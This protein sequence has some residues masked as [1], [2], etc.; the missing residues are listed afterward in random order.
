MRTYWTTARQRSSLHSTIREEGLN[1]VVRNILAGA[2]ALALGAAAVQAAPNDPGR[3]KV[4]AAAKA[5]HN[6]AIER[7]RQWIALPT[8]ANMGLN[9]P[10]GAEYMKQLALD[11]GFQKARIV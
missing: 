5:S 6:E 4:V 7:L 8:I 11:A 10:K 9:T 3:S 2:A 1:M